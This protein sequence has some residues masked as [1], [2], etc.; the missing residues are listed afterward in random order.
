ML[1]AYLFSVVRE[2]AL[3]L[4]EDTEALVY[5]RDI[6]IID[7]LREED[8]ITA[9]IVSVPTEGLSGKQVNLLKDSLIRDIQRTKLLTYEF[10]EINEFL[11]I[12]FTSTSVLYT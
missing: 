4:L 11:I 1:S 3:K 6:E 10:S 8:E 9:Y 2:V 12:G 5:K 7:P